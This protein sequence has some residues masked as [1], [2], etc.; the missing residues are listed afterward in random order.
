MAKDKI[1]LED[2]G[3]F[4]LPLVLGQGSPIIQS[5]CEGE[6]GVA[7]EPPLAVREALRL[8]RCLRGRSRPVFRVSAAATAGGIRGSPTGLAPSHSRR[9]SLPPVAATGTGSP[10]AESL[11]ASVLALLQSPQVLE[12]RP[13]PGNGASRFQ[14]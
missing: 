8:S 6:L 12:K 13:R 9:L 4:R 2:D 7:L 14:G 1:S 10:V 5:S 11:G 3:D